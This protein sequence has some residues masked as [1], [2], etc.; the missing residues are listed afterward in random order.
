MFNGE[1]ILNFKIKTENGMTFNDV[2]TGLLTLGLFAPNPINVTIE[3]EVI[4]LKTTTVRH[5]A[6]IP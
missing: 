2:L 3:G 4:R 6:A 5:H 1:V